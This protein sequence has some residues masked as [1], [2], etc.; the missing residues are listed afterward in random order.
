MLR[1][2]KAFNG[3]SF[4]YLASFIKHLL[5]KTAFS[6]LFLKCF[7]ILASFSLMFLMD[8]FLLKKTYSC[9][10]SIPVAFPSKILHARC[11]PSSVVEPVDTLQLP[12][13]PTTEEIFPHH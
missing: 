9:N 3:C 12:S 7:I 13:L 4:Y 1:L 10:K 6:C 8:M 5:V 11:M 2:C